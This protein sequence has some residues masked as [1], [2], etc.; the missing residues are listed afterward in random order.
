MDVFEKSRWRKAED[1]VRQNFHK[2]RFDFHEMYEKNLDKGLHK[3][4]PQK[5]LPPT[6][7]PG[8]WGIWQKYNDYG[9]NAN[10][11]PNGSESAKLQYY[12]HGYGFE[13]DDHP[14]FQ[15][16][17]SAYGR[18]PPSFE[19]TPEESHSLKTTFTT[20][21]AKIGMPKN[22]SLNIK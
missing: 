19:N 18:F 22:R 3:D 6:P 11:H 13:K 15:T 14:F 21:L 7:L 8:L 5:P 20:T 1:K 9:C 16:T 10:A 2:Q 4:H 12:G 17:S